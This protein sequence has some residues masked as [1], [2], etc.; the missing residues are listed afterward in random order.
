MD[1]TT[2]AEI[3]FHGAAA[4]GALIMLVGYIGNAIIQSK[5]S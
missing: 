4:L 5:K 1:K 2:K 3:A